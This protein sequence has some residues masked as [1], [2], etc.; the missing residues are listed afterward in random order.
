MKQ[1]EAPSFVFAGV[2]RWKAGTRNGL[3]RLRVGT[4][5][6]WERLGN[7]LPESA[8]VMAIAVHPQDRAT[9]IVGTQD[10]PWRST[11]HGDSWHRLDFPEAGVQVWA[12]AFHPARPDTVYAGVSPVGVFRSDD[13]GTR[14]RRMPGS[15]VPDRLRMVGFVNRVM[16]F[17]FHPQ[18]PD[19]IYA[20]MEVN[21]VMRSSDGGE[22]WQDCNDDL[23]RLAAQ[24]ALRS[25]ILTDFDQEGMLDLHALVTTPA[26]PDSVWIACRMGVFRSDDGARSWRDIG[27][28][29]HAPVT[30]TRDL[31]VSPQDPRTFYATFSVSSNGE[32]GALYRSRDL[33][34]TWTRCL[35]PALT[36]RS[37]VMAVAPDPRDANIVHCAARGGQVYGTRDGGATWREV[38]LPDGSLG[39]YA[40]VAG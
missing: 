25:R 26:A 7:G 35:D 27:V 39:T 4:D 23:L 11:D 37:T 29:R 10:G 12:M 38:P 8:F 17:A 32:T 15:S 33:G 30:Y 3:F 20:A 2:T 28:G 1:P 19:Q 21:G 36:P 34:E 5:A 18:R 16:R 6:R 14:W 40:L 22:H 24:P 31:R 9:L 13:R